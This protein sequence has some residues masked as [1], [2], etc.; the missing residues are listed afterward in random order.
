MREINVRERT[1]LKETKKV[2]CEADGTHSC[3][4]GI[5]AWLKKEVE[6]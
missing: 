4:G 3:D 1:R 6:E 5:L 2:Y